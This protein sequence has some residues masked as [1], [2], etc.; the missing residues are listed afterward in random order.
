MMKLSLEERRCKP[1]DAGIAGGGTRFLY[2]GILLKLEIDNEGLYG[3][4]AFAMKVPLHER[5]CCMA[6]S[7]MSDQV[8]KPWSFELKNSRPV[9]VSKQ[10]LAD[11]NCDY[12]PAC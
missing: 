5:K 12:A 10:G 9:Y 6:I 7:R 8:W 3:S 1:I 4:D 2:E 11:I